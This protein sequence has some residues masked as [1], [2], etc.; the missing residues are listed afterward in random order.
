MDEVLE[1][2]GVTHEEH[3]GVVA[4]QIEVALVG[5][6]LQREPSGVANRVRIALFP[7]HRG[8]AGEHRGALADLGEKTRL[9]EPGDVLGDLE[10][11]VGTGALGMHDPLGDALAVEVLHLLHDIVVVQHGRPGRPHRE[12]VLVARS[13]DPRVR[14]RHRRLGVSHG[15]RAP[16]RR[17]GQRLLQQ[18]PSGS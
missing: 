9:G 13:G 6:E 5:V 2:R 1:L 4:D 17:L 14:R 7:G 8:E 15:L 3:R 12:R 18:P 10:E 11:S 16:R